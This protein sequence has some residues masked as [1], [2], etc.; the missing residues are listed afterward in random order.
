MTMSDL[1]PRVAE[2][3]ACLRAAVAD[4]RGC[5]TVYEVV[6][7]GFGGTAAEAHD[8]QMFGYWRLAEDGEH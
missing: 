5:A 3:V 2:A 6:R 4:H 8:A 7:A 1:A